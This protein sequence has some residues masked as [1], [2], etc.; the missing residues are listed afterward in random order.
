MRIDELIAQF[1]SYREKDV[2]DPFAGT[3]YAEYM[4]RIQ[5]MSSDEHR[6]TVPP[7]LYK[8]MKATLKAITR[9]PTINDNETGL[10]GAASVVRAVIEQSSRLKSQ[11]PWS[12]FLE[13]LCAWTTVRVKYEPPQRDSV[14]KWYLRDHKKH[15]RRYV[16]QIQ[17]R[18][19]KL[20]NMIESG[21]LA[22]V[23]SL[24][25]EIE[26]NIEILP[27]ALSGHWLMAAAPNLGVYR[28]CIKILRRRATK[29]V[30][31]KVVVLSELLHESPIGRATAYEDRMAAYYVALGN[32]GI[33]DRR[34]IDEYSRLYDAAIALSSTRMVPRTSKSLRLTEFHPDFKY[35]GEFI[36]DYQSYWSELAAALQGVALR[37]VVDIA[38]RYFL[39][40]EDPRRNEI[41]N[42]GS[43]NQRKGK[44]DEGEAV[45]LSTL[46][47][48][49]FDRMVSYLI[50]RRIM[51]RISGPNTKRGELALRLGFLARTDGDAKKGGSAFYTF[52][53]VRCGLSTKDWQN[54]YRIDSSVRQVRGE[55]EWLM[56][57]RPPSVGNN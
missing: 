2:D 24:S 50:A 21:D 34:L 9:L 53:T 20:R 8:P 46:L 1:A 13:L 28:D 48:N 25:N 6:W 30:Q 54:P 36:A 10:H 47:E 42:F 45:N 7:D 39:P 32:K 49:K 23:I 41:V 5:R 43:L 37:L 16:Q 29:E 35:T 14:D 56:K 26:V 57:Y 3:K 18:V 31:D 33:I 40:I 38:D 27:C 12:V 4:T 55:I 19:R 22:K 15:Q 44:V 11:I 52:A 51:L 17:D